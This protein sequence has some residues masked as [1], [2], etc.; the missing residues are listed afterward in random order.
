LRQLFILFERN[1]MK[2]RRGMP[3]YSR[4]FE[5]VYDRRIT[6]RLSKPLHRSRLP[7]ETGRGCRALFSD[8]R[9]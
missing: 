5:F 8:R 7:A 6:R 1:M 9:F 3:V 2:R 4:R